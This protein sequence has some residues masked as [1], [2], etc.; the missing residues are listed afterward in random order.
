MSKTNSLLT[1][2]NERI[3]SCSWR[4]GP[5]KLGS[6]DWPLFLKVSMHVRVRK[7]AAGTSSQSSGEL[8]WASTSSIEMRILITREIVK[9]FSGQT[10]QSQCWNASQMKTVELWALMQV[11][12]DQTG[13]SSETCQSLH[14]RFV[15]PSPCRARCAVRTIWLMPTNKLSRWILFLKNREKRVQTKP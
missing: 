9:R 6:R 10:K 2:R 13:L 4:Y 14:L 5:A 11:I 1:R 8:V 7:V 15:H 12:V 3:D